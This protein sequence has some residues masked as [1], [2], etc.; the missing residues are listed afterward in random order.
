MT[1]RSSVQTEAAAEIPAPAHILGTALPLLCFEHLNLLRATVR[2]IYDVHVASWDRRSR[3]YASP[4]PSTLPL[5]CAA[6]QNLLLK[7]YASVGRATPWPDSRWPEEIEGDLFFKEKLHNRW[8][9]A[10]LICTVGGS[11]LV[12]VI[13]NMLYRVIKKIYCPASSVLLLQF[14]LMGEIIGG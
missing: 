5:T 7:L 4:S 12:H 3:I 10:L 2:F 6:T 8:K 11:L 13:G 1:R 9:R 14:H